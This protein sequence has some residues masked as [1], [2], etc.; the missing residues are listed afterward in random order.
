MLT[1]SVSIA[2]G[3]GSL[4]HNN[5]VFSAEN[6]DVERTKDNIIYKRESLE[7]AYKNCFEQAIH[8]YN[9]KQKRADRKINGVPDRKSVV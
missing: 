6:V 7:S 2:K 3:K 5:R 8:D 9:A 4:T 1:L